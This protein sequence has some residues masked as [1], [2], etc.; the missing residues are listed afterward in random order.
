MGMPL[1]GVAVFAL[2]VTLATILIMA[3]MASRYKQR[4]LQHQERM[5]ALA[6][7]EALPQSDPAP[8]RAPFNPRVLLLRGLL[9]L[10]T[11]LAITVLLTGIALL[12]QHQEP[13]WLRV[14]HANAAKAA[15][16]S[17]AEIV[18]IMNDRHSEGPNPGIALIGL[19]PIAVGV[20]YLITWRAERR[21]NT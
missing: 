11:G 4:E 8:D 20:A 6:R 1:V 7:G 3:A 16:A 5:A 10:C 14:D 2:V 17:E 18:Q 21:V 13:A 9:W 12:G 15:G 19:I